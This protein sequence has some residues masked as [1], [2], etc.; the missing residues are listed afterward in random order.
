MGILPRVDCS[1]PVLLGLDVLMSKT[2][3]GVVKLL[4]RFTEVGIRSYLKAF[5]FV[6]VLHPTNK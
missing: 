5:D 4:L 2:D 6:L 3:F 1:T